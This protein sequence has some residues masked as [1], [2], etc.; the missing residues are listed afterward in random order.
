MIWARERVAKFF[1]VVVFCFIERQFYAKL[2]AD[3]LSLAGKE[4]LVNFIGDCLKNS[5]WD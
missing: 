2:T 3:S 4:G 1:V 5:L